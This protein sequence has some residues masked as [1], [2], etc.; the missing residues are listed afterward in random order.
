MKKTC[1][2][3]YYGGYGYKG[4]KY[5]MIYCKKRNTKVRCGKQRN[6]CKDFRA[7]PPEDRPHLSYTGMFTI[8]W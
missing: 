5:G 2:N 8:G 7:S 3:C 6:N 1:E 4:P